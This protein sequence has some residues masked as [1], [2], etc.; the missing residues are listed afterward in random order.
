MPLVLAA[1]AIALAGACN[2]DLDGGAACPSLCPGQNVIVSDTVLDA[3][4]FD[5]VIAGAQGIGSEGALLLA[6]RGDTLDTRV[7]LRFDSLPSTATWAGGDSTITAVDSAYLLLRLNSQG[8]RVRSPVRIDLY[9]V[10][11]TAADTSTAAVVALFR[12]DRLLGGSTL[13]TNQVKDSMRVYFANDKLLAKVKGKQRL[14]V[15]LRI[16]GDSSAVLRLGSY[17]ASMPAFLKFDPVPQDTAVKEVTIALR[18]DTPT[19]NVELLLD[20]QDYFVVAKGP[21]PPPDDIHVIGGLPARRSYFR[22]DVP[23][24]ILD[25]ATVLRATLLLHQRP[26]RYLDPRDSVL[27]LPTVVLAGQEVTDVVR[28]AALLSPFPVDTVRLAPGD[29]GVKQIEVA[30]ALRQWS[31]TTNPFKQQRALVI[32]ANDEGLGPFEAHFFSLRSP[33]ALRPRLRVSYSLRTTFGIP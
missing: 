29:S 28:S 9:D 15:G 19:D 27:I 16:S 4:T 21:P 13:D 2:Q 3:I 20:L 6:A 17:D 22:F 1:G 30:A 32:R 33:S 31:S 25:S 24:R 23:V 10:D 14:R 12:P 26:N 11:T 18:S 8:T 5:T 7:V